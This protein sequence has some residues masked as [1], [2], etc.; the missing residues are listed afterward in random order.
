M[1]IGYRDRRTQDFAEGAF[2]AAFQGFESQAA[3]R[4]SILNAAPSLSALRAMPSN[5][6]EALHGDR[7][8]QYS[9]RINRQWRI[10]FTWPAGSS[11]P[12]DVEIVDYH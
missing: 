2:V 4:L 9:I 11:G 1:I 12:Y 6:L 5:R 3:R 10:C 8:G 7:L